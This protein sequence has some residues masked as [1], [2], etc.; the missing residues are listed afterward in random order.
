[1]NVNKLCF[2]KK[3]KK[4][5][6]EEEKSGIGRDGQQSDYHYLMVYRPPFVCPFVCHSQKQYFTNKEQKQTN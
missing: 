5:K 6:K 2:K 3:E 1:M 4:K